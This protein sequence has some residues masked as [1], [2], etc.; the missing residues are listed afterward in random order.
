[1]DGSQVLSA[2]LD[3]FEPPPGDEY[4]IETLARATTGW[5][6]RGAL[7][8]SMSGFALGFSGLMLVETIL[9]QIISWSNVWVDWKSDLVMVKNSSN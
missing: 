8:R 7:E 3:H 9:V 1:L 6:W 4:D 2:A 5:G